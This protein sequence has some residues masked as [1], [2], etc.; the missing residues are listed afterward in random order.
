MVAVTQADSVAGTLTTTERVQERVR[1]KER[2]SALGGATVT[3]EAMDTMKATIKPLP[4][5]VI[6]TG[7]GY[8][9]G[10]GDG[11]GDGDGGG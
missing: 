10:Y 5:R 11:N 8:G 7:Y 3:E 1:G 4:A 9:S 2:A 6:D